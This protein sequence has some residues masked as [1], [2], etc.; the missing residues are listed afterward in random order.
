MFVFKRRYQR[1]ESYPALMCAKE[2]KASKGLDV[3]LLNMNAK[4]ACSS[5]GFA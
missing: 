2:K 5:L 1:V 3:E 4:S